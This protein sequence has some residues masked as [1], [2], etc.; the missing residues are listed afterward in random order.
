MNKLGFK[1]SSKP[2]GQQVVQAIVKMTPHSFPKGEEIMCYN[3][4]KRGDRHIRQDV[5]FKDSSLYIVKYTKE[6]QTSSVWECKLG[7]SPRPFARVKFG[8]NLSN[9]LAVWNSDK[10]LSEYN[11]GL[12]RMPGIANMLNKQAQLSKYPMERKTIQAMG[13]DGCSLKEAQSLL[14][15]RKY[16]VIHDLLVTASKHLN[17]S[18]KVLQDS[19][20]LVGSQ[21]T[22]F[23]VYR[24]LV[25]ARQVHTSPFPRNS[26]GMYFSKE[27]AQN[28]CLVTLL[29]HRQS[30][31]KW[32][33]ME[34][35]LGNNKEVVVLLK[36]TKTPGTCTVVCG[37][38]KVSNKDT[39]FRSFS[40]ITGTFDLSRRTSN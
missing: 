38:F 6:D 21:S 27:I 25:E 4:K 2:Q 8:E 5:V 31:T 35:A 37:I 20:T 15:Q 9:Y 33:W 40:P 36:S 11:K 12:V 3:C 26:L 1:L 10:L 16:F 18:I 32:S 24:D 30:Q 39:M 22:G 34:E 17:I 23:L 7:C 13:Y 19:L 14:N 29:L 28:A